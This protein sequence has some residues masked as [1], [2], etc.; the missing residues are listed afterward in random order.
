MAL[1]PSLKRR[2]TRLSFFGL[3]LA[4]SFMLGAT[5][6]AVIAARVFLPIMTAGMA[7]GLVGLASLSATATIDALRTGDSETRKTVLVG[8]KESIALQGQPSTDPQLANWILPA[9]EQC[10]TDKIVRSSHLPR[11][12]RPLLKARIEINKGSRIN[13]DAR[14][15]PT[16]FNLF[17][18]AAGG[19]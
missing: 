16:A 18:S 13:Q 3:L 4:G 2:L 19:R 15:V 9:L 1:S 12:S 7:M 6:T 17:T 5:V 8:L 10:M 11:R 14:S